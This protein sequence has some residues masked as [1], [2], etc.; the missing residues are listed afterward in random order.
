M[1]GQ[2]CFRAALT[3][4]EGTRFYHLPLQSLVLSEESGAGKGRDKS[5]V[6]RANTTF[7]S[8]P[9]VNDIA[10]YQSTQMMILV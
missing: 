5:L 7:T 3:F 10:S 1:K 2:S 9:K 6:N 8:S 4:V